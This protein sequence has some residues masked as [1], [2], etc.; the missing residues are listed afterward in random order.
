MK[1][2]Q[3]AKEIVDVAIIGAGAAGAY[4]A[5]RLTCPEAEQSPVLRKLRAE[6]GGGRL[7]IRL[8]E[9]GS[10]V[11]GRLFSHRFDGLPHYPAELGG[12][13]FSRLHANVYGLCKTQLKEELS[14][15]PCQSYNGG[16]KLQYAR[17]RRFPYEKYAKDLPLPEENGIPYF[18]T[19]HEARKSPD[20]L[21]WA[22]IER[23]LG[24]SLTAQIH[25]IRAELS[26]R[27]PPAPEAGTAGL[28]QWVS[29]RAEA[30]FPK[31]Q[32]LAL[33]MREATYHPEGAQAVALWERGYWN[34]LSEQ[35]SNE[36]Y[37]LCTDSNFTYSDFRNGNCY[38]GILSYLGVLFTYDLPGLSFWDLQEGN[39]RL[40]EVLIEKFKAAGGSVQ[41]GRRLFSIERESSNGEPVFALSMGLADAMPEERL[42]ARYV[43]LALP[44]HALK[45]FDSSTFLYRDRQFREDIESVFAVPATKLAL[46]FDSPW[47]KKALLQAGNPGQEEDVSGY[48]T[49]D[50]PLR[51]CYYIGAE[52]DGKA[53]VTL[54]SDDYVRQFWAGYAPPGADGLVQGLEELRDMVRSARRMLEEMHDCSVPEPVDIVFQDWGAARFGGGWHSWRS[55]VRSWEVS[56]RIRQPVADANVFICGEAFSTQQG[57]IE[58]A[59]NTAEMVLE[60]H[61]GMPRP[62]WVPPVYDFGP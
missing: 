37:K 8:F 62:T 48:S 4:A 17:R 20:A 30:I 3:A 14:A 16:F 49:T 7:D 25:A 31:I 39:Q 1:D 50:L 5:Y 10:R 55:R 40:P 12:Q 2:E 59:I 19:P 41:Q 13:G 60:E 11:G 54:L 43:I 46:V 38:N 45:K 61:F 15:R 57:W 56:P 24:K 18:L 32:S 6:R 51:A 22:V 34:V 9:A 42:L 29:E 26:A 33:A 35:F 52:E 28:E 58:G 47:W 21:L 36:A 53:L 27:S 23:V 44:Q